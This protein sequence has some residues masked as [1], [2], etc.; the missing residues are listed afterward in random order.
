MLGRKDVV[1]MCAIAGVLDLTMVSDIIHK[2]LSTLA[3]S[4]PD[5]NGVF[6]ASFPSCGD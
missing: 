2:M 4:G 3:R 5:G 1:S 6:A